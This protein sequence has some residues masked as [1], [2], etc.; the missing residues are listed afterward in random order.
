MT[1]VHITYSG[2]PLDRAAQVRTDPKQLEAL[3]NGGRAMLL[4]VWNMRHLFDPAPRAGAVAFTTLEDRWLR[5][6]A[7]PVFLGMR[8]DVPWFALG[9]PDSEA[10]PDLGV[11]GEFRLLNEVVSLLPADEAAMVAYARAMVIWHS[12]HLH[13]GRCGSPTEFLEGGHSR[14]CRN[15]ACA[16][17]SFPRTD[18]AVITLIEDPTGT[19]ALLGRQSRWPQGMHSV[20]AGF[21][22]PGESL[23]ECV[24]RETFEETGIRVGEVRYQASQPWP[25]PASIMLGFRARALTTEINLTDN[26]LESCTWYTRAELR[27]FGEMGGPYADRRLPNPFSIARFLVN[28]W[29]AEG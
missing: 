4:P 24:I 15:P 12:N 27:S 22:E 16:H 18:P 5:P 20:I 28:T 9:L 25:F 17:R 29:L 19:R 1:R 3:L 14:Q 2:A 7:P 11:A 8:D 26:E 6:E 23:E 10:P 13:C 21:V